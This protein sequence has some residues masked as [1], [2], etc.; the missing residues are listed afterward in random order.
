MVKRR[1]NM[2]TNKECEYIKSA[3]G[4]VMWASSL[5]DNGMLASRG[6]IRLREDKTYMCVLMYKKT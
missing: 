5:E 1:N 6:E 4:S 2:A 3:L